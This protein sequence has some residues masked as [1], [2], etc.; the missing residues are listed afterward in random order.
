MSLTLYLF[1]LVMVNPLI[2][3]YLCQSLL[4][5]EFCRLVMGH[6]ASELKAL[7]TFLCVCIFT[8][9]WLVGLTPMTRRVN[10]SC[11]FVKGKH[12]KTPPKSET[13]I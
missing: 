12:V 1:I 10:L 8:L 3:A 4:I 7:L 5:L 9:C 11:R 2:V 6:S 13:T